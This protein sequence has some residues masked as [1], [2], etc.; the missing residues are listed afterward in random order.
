PT[1]RVALP[2]AEGLHHVLPDDRAG[3]VWEPPPGRVVASRRPPQAP[4]ADRPERVRHGPPGLP[5]EVPVE[6][7]G[8]ESGVLADQLGDLR[9]R[10]VAP[11]GQGRLQS[12]S[13]PTRATAS[14]ASRSDRSRASRVTSVRLGPRRGAGP[15]RL[16]QL[17]LVARRPG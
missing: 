11:R 14:R 13:R 4:E 9:C 16:A 3:P 8:D 5:P 6:D 12:T 7:V 17:L 10:H 15:A 1:P 2:P